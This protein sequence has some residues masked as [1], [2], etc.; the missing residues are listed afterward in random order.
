ME[1]AK[2]VAK[3]VVVLVVWEVVVILATMRVVESV[4]LIVLLIA[5]VY[6]VNLRSY[7]LA[8][9]KKLFYNKSLKEER[10]I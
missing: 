7:S 2:E 5:M 8:K 1:D 3:V 10:A 6:K 4:A 9:I